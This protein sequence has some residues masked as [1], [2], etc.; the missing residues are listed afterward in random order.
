MTE[1]GQEPGPQGN[2]RGA[3]TIEHAADATERDRI[4]QAGSAKAAGALVWGKTLAT[5]AGAVYPLILVRLLGKEQVGTLLG[6]LLVYDAVVMVFTGGYPDALVFHMATAAP[7]QRRAVVLQCARGLTALGAVGAVVLGLLALGGNVLS[8]R[9][10]GKDFVDAAILL[11]LILLPIFDLPSRLLPNLLIV[12]KRAR[13]VAWLGVLRTLVQSTATLVPIALGAPLWVVAAAFAGVGVLWGGIFLLYVW[14]LYGRIPPEPAAVSFGGLTRFAVPLGMTDVV[15]YLNQ[16]WDRYLIL[17]AFPVSAVALY[18]AGAW[19]LPVIST[20]A[21]AVGSAY[22]PELVALFRQGRA[23]DA[24]AVWR[25]SIRKVS[26]L[27]VPFATITIVA[28]EDLVVLLFTA[29]YREASGIFRAYAF[30]T[31]VRVAAFGSVIVAAGRPRYILY[32]A[33]VACLSNIALSIPLMAWMGFVGPA[34]G[35]A[36]AIVPTYAAYAYFIGRASGVAWGSVLPL[37]HFTAVTTAALPGATAAHMLSTHWVLGPAM[38]LLLKAAVVLVGFAL[39]GSASKLVTRA[40]WRY[41]G[42]WL[43]MRSLRKEAPSA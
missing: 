22:Q 38:S 12:E 33:V 42:D 7:A 6:V 10:M 39:V 4:A 29:E 19:Q 5:L 27:V 36:L 3:A 18:Q 15:A 35:T 16:Q 26:L 31:L 37:R 13:D 20:L 43:M 28:A 2:P 30:L 41:F 1:L 21:Y 8:Q 23:A 9:W 34:V 24:I 14:V 40:D 32:A 25:Q 17:F 11:P